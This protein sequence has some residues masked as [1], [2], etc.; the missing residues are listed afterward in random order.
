MYHRVV[1]RSREDEFLQSGMYV[2]P[3]TFDKH[4]QFLNQNCQV[5]ALSSLQSADRKNEYGVPGKPLCI[6]TFD[7]GWYDFYQYA[8]PIL[9]KHGVPATVFLPTEFV[10]SNRWFWTD[11][12]SRLMVKKAVRG[13]IGKGGDSDVNG[14]IK[15]IE[16][17]TG[18]LEHRIEKGIQRL[19]AVRREKIEVLIERLANRWDI[20]P[21]RE[22]RA[23]LNWEEIQEM[24]A[25]GLINFGSHTASHPILATLTHE[26][27]E[28]ELKRSRRKLIEKQVVEPG[29]IPFC[30]PNGVYNDAVVEAVKACGYSL[31]VS[32]RYGWADCRSNPYTLK[33]IGIHQ[34]MTGT[35]AMYGC[36]ITGT[37]Q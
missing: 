19:K 9:K 18:C 28:A 36:R 37:L 1:P 20:D 8:Y 14:L 31:G 4:I 24:F 15:E 27:I 22:G 3:E 13:T 33:R 5:G 21:I 30:Y 29:F 32:T 35:D 7:D 2:T 23:F 34:D 26:E 17:L 16:S 11:I 25:S 10:G 12:F 6:L